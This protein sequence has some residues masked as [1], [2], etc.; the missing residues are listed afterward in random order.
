MYVK[1]YILRANNSIFSGCGYTKKNGSLSV[2]VRAFVS[3]L[4]CLYV[5][6]LRPIYLINFF[7]ICHFSKYFHFLCCLLFFFFFFRRGISFM[8]SFEKKKEIFFACTADLITLKRQ[9]FMFVHWCLN[10]SQSQYI[11]FFL[12]LSF[13]INKEEKESG[14]KVVRMIGIFEAS[15]FY[16]PLAIYTVEMVVNIHIY[17]FHWWFETADF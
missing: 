11:Q 15:G 7:R 16:F 8:L 2:C 5:G 14:S 1:S 12:F 10:W 17:I 13:S 4:F 3:S 9:K 6:F